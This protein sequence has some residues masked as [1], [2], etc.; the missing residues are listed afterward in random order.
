LNKAWRTEDRSAETCGYRDL[1]G[2]VHEHIRFLLL[3]LDYVDSYR[4]KVSRFSFWELPLDLV[5]STIAFS[6]ADCGANK[7][8]GI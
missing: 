1:T 6:K 3:P 8:L 4:I 5:A 7:V 2:A